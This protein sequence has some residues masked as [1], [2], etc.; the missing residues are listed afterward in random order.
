[1]LIWRQASQDRLKVTPFA[2]ALQANGKKPDARFVLANLHF[3]ID[4]ALRG[5]LDVRVIDF[6]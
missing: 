6:S 3:G 1:M 2:I 5:D 4:H